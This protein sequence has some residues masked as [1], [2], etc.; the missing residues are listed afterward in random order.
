MNDLEITSVK[1]EAQRFL[2]R[3]TE[4]EAHVKIEDKQHDEHYACPYRAAIRRASLDLSRALS[5]LRNR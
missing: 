5:R 2:S 1:L 4:F 3:I